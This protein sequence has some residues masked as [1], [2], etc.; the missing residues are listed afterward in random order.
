MIS[1]MLNSVITSCHNAP[2]GVERKGN[3]DNVDI[4]PNKFRR[5]L[6]ICQQQWEVKLVL[7]R[8]H[9]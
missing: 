7:C 8:E 3:R 6:S 2:I 5:E 1:V 9:P 4:A